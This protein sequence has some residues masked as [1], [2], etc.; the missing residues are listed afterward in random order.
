MIAIEDNIH[1]YIH[2]HGWSIKIKTLGFYKRRK[3]DRDI[4]ARPPRE[5]L[6]LVAG[7]LEA[8]A[9]LLKADHSDICQSLLPYR[10]HQNPRHFS[11]FFLAFTLLPVKNRKGEKKET[12]AE[13]VTPSFQRVRELLT[14]T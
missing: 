6:V 12:L 2:I 4:H 10:L 1:A 7:N 9:T 8:S 14:V 11:P 5:N 13:S 3:T